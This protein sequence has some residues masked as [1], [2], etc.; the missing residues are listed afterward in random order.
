MLENSG[1]WVGLPKKYLRKCLDTWTV[2]LHVF[3][4]LLPQY[5]CAWMS[6]QHLIPNKPQIILLFIKNISLTMYLECKAPF[7]SKL[8]AFLCD[9]FSGITEIWEYFHG[10]MHLVYIHFPKLMSRIIT[11]TNVSLFLDLCRTSR[12]ISKFYFLNN[13]LFITISQPCIQK[14]LSLPFS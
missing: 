9:M 4:F 6:Y 13:V 2:I 11:I 3:Y 5:M 14:Y 12:I 10:I 7:D 8:T 1:Y